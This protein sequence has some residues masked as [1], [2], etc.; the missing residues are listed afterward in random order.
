MVK[1][2]EKK[3]LKHHR[4]NQPASGPRGRITERSLALVLLIL[5]LPL[6]L[7][8]WLAVR[9]TSRGPGFYCCIR[10]GARRKPIKVWKFRTMDATLALEAM[11]AIL[12]SDEWQARYKLTCD[13]R[14][15]AVGRL[16]RRFSLDEL[17]QLWNVVNGSMAF[18]GPR[19]ITRAEDVR[20]GKYSAVIH[21]VKPGMTGLWQVSGRN[22]ISYHR[23]IAMNLWY[24]RYRSKRL[25]MWILWKTIGAICGGKGAF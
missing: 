10:L 2:M 24:V 22:L 1:H 6:Q 4:A 23:R 12:E 7:L 15:T 20:Y 18:I 11:A 8:V 16:L 14:L 21:S 3:Q 5:S 9:L 19:P 25:N 17:P 13:P